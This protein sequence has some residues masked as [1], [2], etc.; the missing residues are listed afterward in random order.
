[1]YLIQTNSLV[2][3]NFKIRKQQAKIAELKIITERLE[4][5]I[6][7]WQS[8]ANLEELI[9]SLEMVEIGEVIYLTDEKEVAVKE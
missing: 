5:N 2:S 6:A 3:C 4:I 9:S 8:P 1:L 7:Q